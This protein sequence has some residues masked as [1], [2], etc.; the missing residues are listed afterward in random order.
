M[1]LEFH[2]DIDSRFHI[3]MCINFV[4]SL[5]NR[6]ND[7]RKFINQFMIFPKMNSKIFKPFESSGF[8]KIP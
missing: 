5:N 3:Q 7:V 8:L 4:E 6:Q 2:T 1:I